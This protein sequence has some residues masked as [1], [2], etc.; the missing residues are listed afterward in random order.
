MTLL[1]YDDFLILMLNVFS[2][3][4]PVQKSYGAPN[5]RGIIS[6]KPCG[7]RFFFHLK[8]ES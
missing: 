3:F 1:R 8:Y 4:L 6:I 2:V 5:S 7:S